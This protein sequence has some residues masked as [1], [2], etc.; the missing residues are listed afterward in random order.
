MFQY[1]NRTKKGTVVYYNEQNN[2]LM[3]IEIEMST[4]VYFD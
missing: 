3:Y 2:I 4:M 1:Y